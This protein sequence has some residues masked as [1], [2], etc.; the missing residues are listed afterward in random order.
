M[1]ALDRVISES[2]KLT[3][4]ANYS[5]WKFR[6]KN[7]LQKEDL[8]EFVSEDQV[9]A[10]VTVPQVDAEDGEAVKNP[11]DAEAAQ[12]LVKRRRRALSILYLSVSDAVI[13]HIKNVNSPTLCWN[14]LCCLYE[15]DSTARKL[16]LRNQ[17]NNLRLEEYGSVSE[18]VMQV[19]TILNQL[20]NI[21]ILIPNSELMTNILAHL[22]ESYESLSNVLIYRKNLPSFIEFSAMLFQEEIRKDIH[23][24]R[25][26][27]HE[28]LILGTRV[29]PLFYS[30]TRGRGCGSH[31][32]LRGGR[33]PRQ[34]NTSNYTIPP[35][36]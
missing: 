20:A 1:A 3:G 29:R 35:S 33:P 12:N 30:D 25:K 10:A 15:N 24:P 17:L 27:V 8:M 16:V 14:I 36:T 21:G 28:G 6:V 19:Q 34:Q 13:P 7:I 18:Y 22:S 9:N 11:A 31:G 5:T 32:G 23:S 26:L 4:T 2:I